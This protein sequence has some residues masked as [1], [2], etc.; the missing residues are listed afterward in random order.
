MFIINNIVFRL[1]HQLNAQYKL[2]RILK[3]HLQHVSVQVYRLQGEQIAGFEITASG[4][5]VQKHAGDVILILAV[6]KI[7]QL[8]SVMYCVP[9]PVAARS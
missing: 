8:V 4:Q 6:I 1:L 2:I 7:V 3:K 9:I 5:M